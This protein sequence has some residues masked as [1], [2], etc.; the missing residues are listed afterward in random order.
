MSRL[1]ALVVAAAFVAGAAGVPGA[2]ANHRCDVDTDPGLAYGYCGEHVR[3]SE[4]P[5]HFRVNK[6]VKPSNISDLQL[7]D[8]VNS[9]MLEWN[10]HWPV[11]T[12]NICGTVLCNDGW[13][14][15]DVAEKDGTNAIFFSTTTSFP[16][17]SLKH[18]GAVGVAC[19][20]YEGTSGAARH[21]IAEID[22]ALSMGETW[23]QPSLVN[24]PAQ[25]AAGDVAGDVYPDLGKQPQYN[26]VGQ[27]KGK[28]DLQSVLTHEL[29]HA[30]GLEDIGST[31]AQWPNRAE[32]AVNYRQTMYRYYYEGTT[33]KRT[34]AEGDI[35][36]LQRIATEV[37]TDG[38]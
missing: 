13:T 8:A 7:A 29:G 31:E 18:L 10:R 28:L 6:N 22:I 3:L 21:R 11:A 17:C 15:K 25:V 37:V 2:H 38:G 1:A 9:A 26:A 5:L 32:D 23:Y 20:F 14:S 16:D 12:A 4:L 27:G 35:A 24:Q 30:L 33:N 36:G 34:L 19:V